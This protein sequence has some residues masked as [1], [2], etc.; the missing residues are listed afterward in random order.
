MMK[1]NSIL[2]EM[3]IIIALFIIEGGLWYLYAVG[4]GT[5]LIPIFMVLIFVLFIILLY[6]KN[7]KDGIYFDKFK[8]HF[9]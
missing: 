7:K 3:L 4:F 8:D 5:T 1:K 6:W 9:K 2:G